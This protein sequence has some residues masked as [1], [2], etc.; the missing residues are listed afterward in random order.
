MEHPPQLRVGS[1]LFSLLLLVPLLW[2][3]GAG[4]D[5][6]R[7][8][9]ALGLAGLLL[10]LGALRGGAGGGGAP[11]LLSGAVAAFVGI[12]LLSMT[13]AHSTTDSA[14]SLVVLLAGLAAFVVSRS[15]QVGEDFVREG[16]PLVLS[17]EGLALGAVGLVQRFFG[18]EAVATEGNTNY[19][20]ALAGLLLP[21]MVGFVWA[22]RD[23][24]RRILAGSAGTALLVLLLLSGSRGGWMGAVAG[25]G[26]VVAALVAKR[27]P[28]ARLGSALVGLAVVLVPLLFEAVV[29]LPEGRG[30]GASVRREIWKS[31]GR[32]IAARPFR[33]VG[34]GNFAVEYPPY[35]SEEEFRASHQFAPGKFVEAEDA[36]S[37]WV[38][39][40]VETGI[41]GVILLLGVACLGARA[42]VRAVRSSSDPREAAFLAGVGG[43]AVAYLVSGGFNTLTLRA[44]HTI[45]FWICL[46][47]L[48]RMGREPA[49][50]PPPPGPWRRAGRAAGSLALFLAAG[51]AWE[52]VR[53]DVALTRAMGSPDARSRIPLLE[54]ALDRRP[55]SW[56]TRLELTRA[57]GKSGRWEDAIRMGREAI[58]IRPH[59]LDALNQ[60]AVALLSTG[61]NVD[62]AEG[63]LRHAVE[64]APYHRLSRYNL[65][66]LLQMKRDWPA[67][68]A[69]FEK[70]VALEEGHGPSHRSLA[71]CLARE[72]RTSEAVAEFRKARALG[73]DVGAVLREEDPDLARDPAFVEFL[74]R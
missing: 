32:M 43:V 19:S 20:G 53:A 64:V 55:G 60:L 15:T 63:I 59:Q 47:I 9:V 16:M 10:G 71:E 38:Q 74:S 29:R 62:E 5:G 66:L 1:I 27:A 7:L 21:A 40:A 22:G 31:S 65:G 51:W 73:I 23:R 41:P 26:V 6:V 12:Q 37:I 3:P 44:S 48:E 46:G 70:A 49:G 24:V 57:Y 42:G 35:R 56:R 11:S 52:G 33:G 69:Q 72:G 50:E 67:A 17:I 58:A 54:R 61:R 18:V 14:G 8:P 25:C 36:H 2:I 30:V 45:L 34:A 39:T 68:R 13:A 28:R 4:Y